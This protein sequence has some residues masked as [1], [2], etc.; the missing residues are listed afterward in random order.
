MIE[1]LKTQLQRMFS[2]LSLITV[3]FLIEFSI[4]IL[5]LAFIFLS[6]F[7]ELHFGLLKMESLM[8]PMARVIILIFLCLTIGSVT[9]LLGSR[10][11]V[12]KTRYVLKAMKQLAEG[13]FQTRITQE[14]ILCPKELKEF[15]EEFNLMAKELGSIEMIRSDF[16]NCLSHEIKTPIVSLRGFARLLKEADLTQEEREEYLDVILGE[17]D[18]LAKLSTNILNLVK[19][20]SQTLLAGQS[21]IELGEQIRR[22]MLMIEAKWEEKKLAL[23]LEI[24]DDVHYYGNG[25]LLSQVWV[26][27]LDNAVKFSPQYGRLEVELKDSTNAVM[28]R[29]RDYGSGMDEET[30][31]YMFEKFYRQDK[32]IAIDGNGLGM[33][34]VKKIVELHSG[35]IFVET[36]LGEGTQIIIILPKVQSS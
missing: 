12:R 35:K 8:E 29:V 23:E 9:T 31:M 7:L 18:R 4:L 22:A 36:T 32:S 1:K 33:T 28:L 34:M 27:V 16:V 24:E 5:T 11:I 6:I 13:N 10:L 26:N 17:S 25:E 15:I 3:F 21:N 14:G 2:K 19:I 20:E 30:K